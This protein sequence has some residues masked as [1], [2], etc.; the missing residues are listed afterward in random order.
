MCGAPFS[1]LWVAAVPPSVGETLTTARALAT[2]RK[3]ADMHNR[4]YDV[5]GLVFGGIMAALAVVCALVPPLSLFMPI[6]LV[7]T[8]VRYG[9]RV[10]TLT[11]AVAVLFS[12]LFVGPIQAFLLTVPGG[13]LPGLV[14]GYGFARKMKPL[15]IG[16]LAVAV[17]FVSFGADYVVTRA[18]LLGGRD[19]IAATLESPETQRLMDQYFT[20]Y[21]KTITAQE[22]KSEADRQAVERAL[23]QITEMRENM[24]GVF[25]ALLPSALFLGGA[26][27]SWINYVLCRLILPRFGH[28]VP[29]PTPFGEFRL[30]VWL[31]WV[32]VILLF[33]TRYLG[34]S[35]V[36]A[37]WW[38]QV[39]INLAGPLLYIF[40][41]VG[42]AV[43]YG[44]LRKRNISKPLSIMLTLLV[45]VMLGQWGMY[46][47][48]ML[49]MWDSLFDFRGLGHGLFKG[50]QGAA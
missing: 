49:A 14:F 32:M 8:Y 50:P 3:H 15:T 35:L 36:N 22:P 24:V 5:R 27:T 29:A 19:P 40:V 21:E 33:G 41:L 39:L 45:L 7:L 9:G 18:A 4:K 46:V 42:L 28:Q 10:A 43:A 1:H 6:P 16:L 34:A 23:A 13:V 38:M 37:P 11:G 47:Y 2:R 31:T 25:W 48:V 12:A 26:L 30:P 44:F 17:F 20:M